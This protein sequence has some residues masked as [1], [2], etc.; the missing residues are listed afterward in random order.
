MDAAALDSI[1]TDLSATPA[2]IEQS[3]EQYAA[4]DKVVALYEPDIQLLAATVKALY[5]GAHHMAQA[6]GDHST[7]EY[8]QGCIAVLIHEGVNSDKLV[9]AAE[10]LQA[11][12]RAIR[13]AA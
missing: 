10:M 4:A 2:P 13:E 7:A 6:H 8:Y 3:A 1:W 11:V 5:Y 9:K 12:E